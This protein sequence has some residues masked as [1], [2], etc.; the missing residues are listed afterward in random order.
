VDALTRKD[1]DAIAMLAR[2]EL[3]DDEA[4]RLC[5]E[6]TAI[7]QHMDRLAAVDT[8]GVEPMTHAVPMALR[9]R[10]DE[11]APSL[12]VEQVLGQAPERDDDGFRVPAIIES[13]RGDAS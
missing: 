6:L 7:L 4:D 11:V 3:S 12:P 10:D 8:E 9:L 2:L 5:R 13:Q 1:V